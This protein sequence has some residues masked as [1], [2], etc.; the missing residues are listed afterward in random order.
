MLL[1]I[2]LESE[3]YWE[4]EVKK[5]EKEINKTD[6]DMQKFIVEQRQLLDSFLGKRDV[7]SLEQDDFDD[8]DMVS[9]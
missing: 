6:E 2:F 5:A 8:W 7:L 1:A 4:E 9:F 3:K